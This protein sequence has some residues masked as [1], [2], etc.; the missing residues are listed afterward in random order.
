M[1]VVIVILSMLLVLAIAAVVLVVKINLQL[2]DQRERLVDQIERSLDE[3]DLCF[4]RLS[5]NAEVNVL[6]DEPVIRE[7][8]GDIRRA[9]NAVLAVASEVVTYGS[10][11]NEDEDN[12]ATR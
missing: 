1:W 11:E 12:D 10:D 6:S 5:R 9:R 3:L 4:Q 7:V 8:M 2:S